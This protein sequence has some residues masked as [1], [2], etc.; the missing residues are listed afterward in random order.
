[1]KIYKSLIPKSFWGYQVEK[2]KEICPRC[3]SV[4]DWKERLK[5]KT[6]VNSYRYY[7]VAVH[8]DPDSKRRRKCYLGPE[9]GYSVGVVTHLE[10]TG[11]LEGLIDVWDRNKYY[12]ENLLESFTRCQDPKVLKEVINIIKS[13]LSKLETH[14]KTLEAPEVTELVSKFEEVQKFKP[15]ISLI[16][17]YNDGSETFLLIVKEEHLKLLIDSFTKLASE[18]GVRFTEVPNTSLYKFYCLEKQLK[19][20]PTLASP[21]AYVSV[22][23]HEQD[24]HV[25][26]ITTEFSVRNNYEEHVVKLLKE[27]ARSINAEFKM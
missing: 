20:I 8:Y 26:V 16:N 4:I 6:G 14:L 9:D 19:K 17:V 13:S 2:Q 11:G 21:I 7:V 27:F 12:L 10:H 22:S 1:M 3:G 25:Y 23:K 24:F 5:V 15:S 18:L